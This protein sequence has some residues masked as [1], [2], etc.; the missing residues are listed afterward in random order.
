MGLSGK[1]VKSIPRD[2]LFEAAQDLRM[3]GKNNVL[4]FKSEDET[5]YLMDHAI[6][7]IIRG[8][9]RVIDIY[10]E[11]YA[12]ENNLS[13][14]EL[15]LLPAMKD[16]E[17]SLFTIEKIDTGKG[18]YLKD[19]FS[20]V[21]LFLYDISSSQTA[22]ER[23]LIAS[24]IF[25]IEGINF[26]SGA[27]CV[28]DDIYLKELKSNFAQLYEKKKHEM[29]W[30]RMMSKY[31]YYFFRKMKEYSAHIDMGFRTIK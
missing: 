8:D 23:Y 11:N 15:K 1:I 26:T 24:R 13:D 16:S 14:D 18:L 31:S 9:K 20:D 29:T 2:V 3:L 12:R 21:E 4:I 7:D 27:A 19:V 22:L 5:S 17:Y 6:F 25:S 30:Q 28:F 10:L